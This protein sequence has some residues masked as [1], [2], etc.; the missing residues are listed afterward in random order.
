MRPHRNK[1][2]SCAGP[3]VLSGESG[4]D[5]TGGARKLHA[6]RLPVGRAGL[7]D[8]VKP[9]SITPRALQHPPPLLS[10]SVC[11]PGPSWEGESGWRPLEA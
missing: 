5:A 9:G 1:Q 10:S 4:P 11:F 6:H 2:L 7:Q 8:A 3:H